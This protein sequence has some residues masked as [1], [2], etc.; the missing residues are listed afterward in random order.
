MDS[1]TSVDH[2]HR[3]SCRNKFVLSLTL[4]RNGTGSGREEKCQALK[5]ISGN[6]P[7]SSSPQQLRFRQTFLPVHFPKQ[8]KKPV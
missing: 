2:A 6:Y 4:V 5:L 1:A 8:Y 3:C 7:G